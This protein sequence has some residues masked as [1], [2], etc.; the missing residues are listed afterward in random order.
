MR[1]FFLIFALLSTVR[2]VRHVTVHKWRLIGDACEEVF[3]AVIT[4]ATG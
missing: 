4:V 1:L 3:A 2:Y